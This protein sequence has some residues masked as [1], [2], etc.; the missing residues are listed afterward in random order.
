MFKQTRK[1][2][3]S[4]CGVGSDRPW[5]PV[6]PIGVLMG[7]ALCVLAGCSSTSALRF[8]PARV[9]V[10]WPAPPDPV[11]IRYAGELVGTSDPRTG[12]AGGGGVLDVLFGKEKAQGMVS[13]M[14]VC[15]EGSRIF[16]ADPGV[17]GVHV[18]DLES[19]DDAIWRP[20]ADAGPMRMPVSLA[21]TPGGRLLVTDSA[22]ASVFVFDRDGGFLGTMGDGLLTRPVGVS[23]DPRDGR[24]FI[25]D[26][27]A[28]VVFV[29]AS[30]GEEIGR[31]G[32]R[33]VGP[34][35]FNFPTYTAVDA[36][37][38]LYVSD[39]LNFRVQVFSPSLDHLFSFGSKGD[40][41]G[42]FAQ[43]K[44]LAVDDA[45]R[46]YVA[47]AQFEAVQLF[48]RAGRLLMAFGHEGRGPGEFWLPVGVHIDAKGRVWIA[49]SYNRRVQVFEYVGPGGGG[50]NAGAGGES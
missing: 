12:R 33:G 20:P 19:G 15:T 37:G 4:R 21:M 23:V 18:F 41:P 26:A 13:P 24:V 45:G 28:H 44:G 11:R 35:Q 47:D 36:D 7:A 50:E 40:M 32:G 17:P 39:S 29:L 10:G 34:G 30:D 9:D 3:S 1:H 42:Y 2:S 49:D 8:E 5:R 31:I 46:V 48:D 27:G 22:D 25:A 6:V 38:R 14:A 16:V 43:P